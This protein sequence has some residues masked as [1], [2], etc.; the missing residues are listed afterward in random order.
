VIWAYNRCYWRLC[1][2]N[3]PFVGSGRPASALG[4]GA[5]TPGGDAPSLPG[6]FVRIAIGV[7]LLLMLFSAELR[8]HF[9]LRFDTILMLGG[10]WAFWHF[11]LRRSGAATDAPTP[12]PSIA[13]VSCGDTARGND[14][15]CTRF[16]ESRDDL[17]VY[18][19]WKTNTKSIVSRLSG[20]IA[21][22]FSR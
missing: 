17:R 5:K 6:T 12:S 4:L 18:N 22:S 3:G 9:G 10:I 7:L 21:G 15:P 1:Y 13:R 19:N 11:C 14:Q 8:L 2:K 16:R 20:E